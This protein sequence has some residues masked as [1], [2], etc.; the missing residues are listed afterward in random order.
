MKEVQRAIQRFVRGDDAASAA[1][2]VA[3]L[4]IAVAARLR[5][6]RHHFQLSLTQ[7]LVA[8]YPVVARIVDERFFAWLA[9]EF[10]GSNP[11]RDPRLS[12]YG[13]S[14]AAFIEQFAAANHVPYLPDV[15]RLEWALHESL[16][17]PDEALLAP[18]ASRLPEDPGNLRLSFLRSVRYV[19]SV[20]PIA[21][22]WTWHRDQPEVSLVLE[23]RPTHLEIRR[24][25]DAVGFREI[26]PATYRLRSTMAHG[27]TLGDAANAATSIEPD[28]N[29]SLALGELF[30]DGILAT[31]N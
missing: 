19:E 25:S 9:H 24:T 4:S 3:Q 6:Y 15:A 2:G 28:F 12:R 20:W 17:A 1:A 27:G 30:G 22:F 13:A 21:T 26:S 10:V 11:P 29:L 16:H 7:A 8:V 31:T 18:S 5:V 14:F 23:R